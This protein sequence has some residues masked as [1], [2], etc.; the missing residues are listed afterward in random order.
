LAAAEEQ[1][2]FL[3]I[4]SDDLDLANPASIPVFFEKNTPACFVNCA[5][6]TAVDKA[7]SEKEIAYAINATAVGI[8]AAECAKRNSLL[9]NISTDYVF[10]GNGTDPYRID[11]VTDP[12]NYYGY[13]KREGEK[14]ALANN[15]KTVIIRTSWLYS[16]H[17]HNFVKTMLRLMKERTELK[18]VNDQTGSPTYAADLA[19]AI[20]S[21]IRSF[22]QGT[23]HTGIYHYSNTGIIS[24]YD[25]ALAIRDRSGLSCDVHP[26][27]SS[28]Y[29]TA[30]KRPVYSAMDTS[31][32][33]RD[34][35]VE[36]RSWE[37]S[38][39][40]CLRLLF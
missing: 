31:D 7:E 35:G 13:T 16:S 38:L 34:F 18:V 19:G 36:L 1:F 15:K 22:D 4:D 21:V 17:G 25:F 5:A 33:V 37:K 6:Y 30:A 11:T 20:I 3:F 14:L 39:A 23:G 9:I 12:V 24:W 40:E 28:A 32:I 10:N 29:P 27:L 2:E 26:Q 8:I